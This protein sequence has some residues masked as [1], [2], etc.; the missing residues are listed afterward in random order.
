ME[1]FSFGPLEGGHIALVDIVLFCPFPI[2]AL[3]SDAKGVHG[4]VH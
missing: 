3:A 4:N 2:L 1:L